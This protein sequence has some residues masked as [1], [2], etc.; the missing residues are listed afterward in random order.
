MSDHFQKDSHVLAE[1]GEW[2]LVIYADR[3]ISL[4]KKDGSEIKS[5]GCCVEDDD[6]GYVRP[7]ADL[8]DQLGDMFLLAYKNERNKPTVY[9]SAQAK[10]EGVPTND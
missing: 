4:L 1:K 7:E 10:A 9:T 8:I 5:L 3:C 6:E 2:Q